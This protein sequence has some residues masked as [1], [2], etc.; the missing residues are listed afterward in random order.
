MPLDSRIHN[1]RGIPRFNAAEIC[2][3]YNGSGMEIHSSLL[4]AVLHD[5]PHIRT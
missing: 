5:N 3:N 1:A 2:S 4:N